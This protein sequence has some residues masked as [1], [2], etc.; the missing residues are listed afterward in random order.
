MQ[1]NKNSRSQILSFQGVCKGEILWSMDA[2]KEKINCGHLLKPREARTKSN[3]LHCMVTRKG[4]YQRTWDKAS[5]CCGS[6]AFGGQREPEADT[7][8]CEKATTATTGRSE[9]S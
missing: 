9:I 5:W 1:S 7:V 4:T 2:E 8:T 3:W 6:T